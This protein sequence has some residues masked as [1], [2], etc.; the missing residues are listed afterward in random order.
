MIELLKSIKNIMDTIATIAGVAVALYGIILGGV[1]NTI[2]IAGISLAISVFLSILIKVK[3]RKAR[4]KIM[5]TLTS[6]FG[7]V[8]K[9]QQK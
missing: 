8:V 7:E 2:L 6:V 9:E 1:W 5:D 4:K 3:K